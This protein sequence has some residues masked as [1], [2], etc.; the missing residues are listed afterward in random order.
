MYFG[1]Y[2][3]I[4]YIFT[5]FHENV[6]TLNIEMALNYRADCTICIK[7]K[8]IAMEYLLLSSSCCTEWF[9]LQPVSEDSPV[10]FQ[11]K[12]VLNTK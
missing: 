1:D 2:M 11:L 5:V 8:K 7:I 10:K 4:C 6:S 9:L 12:P 3:H